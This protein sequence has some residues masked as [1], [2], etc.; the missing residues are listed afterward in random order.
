MYKNVWLFVDMLRCKCYILYPLNI[1]L[2]SAFPL[3]L[4]F[5]GC[6]LLNLIRFGG[7]HSCFHLDLDTQDEIKNKITQSKDTRNKTHGKTYLVKQNWRFFSISI[8]GNIS[9]SVGGV[10]SPVSLTAPEHL[11]VPW[12]Q[13]WRRIFHLI[14]QN[15]LRKMPV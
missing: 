4:L 11:L 1:S 9:G 6:F 2:E 15:I 7:Y 8:R 13:N 10:Q 12:I 3:K 14:W 5:G